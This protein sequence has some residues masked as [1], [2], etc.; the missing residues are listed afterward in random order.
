[1]ATRMSRRAAVLPFLSNHFNVTAEE[2][3]DVYK[4][5]AKLKIVFHNSST[6]TRVLEASKGRNKSGGV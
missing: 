1:M 3:D 6:V 4:L 5:G 2:I